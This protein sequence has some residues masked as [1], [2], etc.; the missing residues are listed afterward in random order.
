VLVTASLTDQRGVFEND[1]EAVET[2]QVVITV[3]AFIYLHGLR[4]FGLT[5]TLWVV[6]SMI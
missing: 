4:F 3:D 1:D 6:A 2:D 5:S